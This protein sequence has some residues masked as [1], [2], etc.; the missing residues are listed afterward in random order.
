MNL[1]IALPFLSLALFV[2]LAARMLRAKK[3]LNR[4]KAG[5]KEQVVDVRS[6]DEFAQGHA[7]KSR[8]IPLDLLEKQLHTLD[9][10]RPVI[11]CCAS[12]ARSQRALD[13][14]KKR[15][16]KDVKNAGSWRN[17]R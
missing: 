17:I 6:P 7:Q 15:G 3:V 1:Q 8:N 14:L 13:L 10:L 9:P 4:S 11:V 16:F 12:G 2:L 5:A